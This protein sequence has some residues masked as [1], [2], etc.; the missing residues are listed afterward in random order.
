MAASETAAAGALDLTHAPLPMLVVD[1]AT[2]LIR[3]VSDGVVQLT[4]FPR[5]DLVGTDATRYLAGSPSPALPLLVSYQLLLATPVLG[6]AAMTQ[7]NGFVRAMIRG[8]SRLREW[9]D[10]ELDVYADV[11]RA[12]ARARASSACYR[13]FLTRELPAVVAGR[14]HQAGELEVPA[15][16]V[17]GGE[18]LLR[19][20]H[21]RKAI[22]TITTDP[23]RL[24][25]CHLTPRPKLE[26]NQIIHER[27]QSSEDRLSASA[28]VR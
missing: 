16:L 23:P 8:G 3:D 15:L 26:A 10:A 27:S 18:S 28:I 13:T 14:G 6:T 5:G 9:T 21:G 22:E 25:R 7:S 1:L 19:T 2:R 24:I 17:M 11:L 4:G 12:P 20:V